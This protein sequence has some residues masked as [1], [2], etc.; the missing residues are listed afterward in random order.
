MQSTIIILREVIECY[1]TCYYYYTLYLLHII[2]V[3]P[4][5]DFQ[6]MIQSKIH[7]CTKNA[8]RSNKL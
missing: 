2:D 4:I 7:T 8:T 1:I 3:A 5:A 6:S